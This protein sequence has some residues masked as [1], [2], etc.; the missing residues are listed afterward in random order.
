MTLIRTKKVLIIGGCGYIGSALFK[1]L[2]NATER[3]SWLDDEGSGESY[4]LSLYKYKVDTID[5]EWFGNFTNPENIIMDFRHLTP[6]QLAKYDVVIL[7]AGH[8]S[9]PMANNS[10]PQ[11][12]FKNNVDNFV[13]LLKKLT[14][15]QK[16]IYAGSSSV[17][18][19]IPDDDCT[20]DYQ[21]LHPSNTYDMTKQ[22]LDRYIRLFP[23]IEFYGLRFGTVNGISENLRTDIMINAMV[24]NAL[25]TGEVKLFNEGIRRPILFLEDLVDA[26]EK[27]IECPEDRRGVYNLSS[28]NGTAGMIAEGVAETVGAKLIRVTQ[29]EVEKAINSKLQAVYDFSISSKKFSETF[30]FNFRG[31]ISAIA[32]QVANHFDEI[33]KTKRLKAVKYA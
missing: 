9:V 4:P 13:D 29:G 8:S 26:V 30:D 31:D 3:I 16:F 6:E 23:D 28:F 14:A 7:L 15:G 24:E 22:D 20:E 1:R 5:L 12:T 21:L 32:G 18:N 33:N 25:Q 27:I 2:T 11:S 10:D 17:Y 19:G